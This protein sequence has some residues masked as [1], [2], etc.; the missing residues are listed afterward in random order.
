MPLRRAD[1]AHLAEPEPFDLSRRDHDP[2]A[3]SGTDA[4]SALDWAFVA[5][6]L[7]GLPAAVVDELMAGV[8]AD[9][10]RSLAELRDPSLADVDRAQRAHRLKGSARTFGL[11]GLGEAAAAVERAAADG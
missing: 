3:V 5:E 6:A 9:A 8:L 4:P 7:D 2:A 11:V 10:R 1:P